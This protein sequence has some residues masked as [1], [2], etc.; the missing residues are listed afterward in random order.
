MAREIRNAV[1]VMGT[2][3][4]TGFG[5][6]FD[7]TKVIRREAPCPVLTVHPPA[8]KDHPVSGPGVGSGTTRREGWG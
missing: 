2:S 3:G 7:P 8:R 4:R 1:V 6:L 5:E